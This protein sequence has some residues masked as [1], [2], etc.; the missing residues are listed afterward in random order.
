MD[1]ATAKPDIPGETAFG[2]GRA[3][4]ALAVAATAAVL[5]PLG[6][7]GSSSGCYYQSSGA[8]NRKGLFYKPPG[9]HYTIR[10]LAIVCM[11]LLIIAGVWFGRR[12]QKADQLQR[13][14][15][16]ADLSNVPEL[17]DALR[18]VRGHVSDSLRH[19]AETI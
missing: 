3:F 15:F 1:L 9:Q 2:I 18:P 5:T 17:I 19:F 13:Q 8:P 10:T 16:T 11:L 7:S 6:G 14:L 4:W 12:V